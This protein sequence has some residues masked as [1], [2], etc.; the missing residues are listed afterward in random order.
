MNNALDEAY[1]LSMKGITKIYGNGFIANKDVDFNLIEGEIHGLLGEN[2]AGKTTLM[3]ILFGHE[4]T[5]MGTI[6]L[7]GRI[8]N[9]DSP[10]KALELGIGMVHQH[11]MLVDSL[12]VA[13]NISLGQEP[14]RKRVFFDDAQ[15]CRSVEELSRQYNLEVDPKALIRDLSV[16]SKQKVEIL[17]V[18]SRG[19]RILILDE[20]TAVLTP[21]ETEELF[22]QLLELKIH[23]LT[24][25]FISHKLNEVKQICDRITILRHGCVAGT[26]KVSDVSIE[27]MSRLMVGH[28]IQTVKHDGNV[29]LGNSVLKLRDLTFINRF[30]LIALDKI[31]FDVREGQILGIAGVEGNGQT[32]LAG[33]LSRLLEPNS[34]S[35]NVLG[36]DLF[37]LSINDLRKLGVSL[38]HEDRMSYGTSVSQPIS[39]N[40]IS[41]RFRKAPWSRKSILHNKTIR[42]GSEDLISSFSIKCDGSQAPVKTLSGGNIQKVVV[43][44]EFSSS[45]KLVIAC[46]PTRGIDVGATAQIQEKLLNLRDQHQIAVLLFSADLNELL[47]VCDAIIV[48]FEGRIVACFQNLADLTPQVLG[49]YMLGI[50]RQDSTELGGAV[51]EA[52]SI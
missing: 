32:E 30:G 2:G 3:K 8:V 48:L 26:A 22:K 9:I 33:I 41:D 16:S 43:A 7:D 34:G 27:E 21:Q 28:F 19:V 42:D 47:N 49:E 50:K 4:K 46:H 38:I 18:L 12:S 37:T 17:K 6:S 5:E 44:R 23:G 52:Q 45:P 14:K 1:L 36:K 13:E 15:A 51:Y 35:V 29:G 20:P 25:V 39:E 40:L 24:I 31:S 11:F 10:I